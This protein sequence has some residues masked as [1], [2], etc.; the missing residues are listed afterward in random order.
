MKSMTSY[1]LAIFMVMFWIFR[2][3]VAFTSSMGIDI[4]FVPMNMNVEI[5][6]LFVCIPCVILVAKRKL[7]GRYHIYNSIW[8][9]FWSRFIFYCNRNYER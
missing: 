2:I 5:I 3:V 7:I 1:L 6:L 4:G 8:N 9:V